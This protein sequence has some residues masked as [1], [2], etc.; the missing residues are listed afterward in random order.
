[1]SS[2]M[3]ENS[4]MQPSRRLRRLGTALAVV[5]M[6]A[7]LVAVASEPAEA[8]TGRVNTSGSP[9]TVR[10]APGTGFDAWTSV[11][12]GASVTI[13]CQVSGSSVTGT[14]G[15]TS[16]GDMLGNGGFVSDAYIYTGSDSQVAPTCTYAAAPPRANPNTKN[17]AISYEFSK[18]G[19][20]AYEGMCLHFQAVS[21]GWGASGFG[22]AESAG[23]WMVSN[24]YMHT[25]GIPP[26]G[27]LVWYHNSAGTGHIVVSL[28]EGKIIGTSVSGGVGVAGYLYHSQYR[29]WTVPYFPRAS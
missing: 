25:S 28:G 10:A 8:A 2:A 1:M 24:G 16:L 23:D 22:S 20:S 17:E 27:A 18:L 4:T 12:D 6:S 26:R 29:G 21:F 3:P 7:A 14:Y 15:T 5:A 13:L 9:L 19:S 11:A